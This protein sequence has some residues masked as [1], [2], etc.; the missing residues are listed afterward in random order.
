MFDSIAIE[1]HKK[2]RSHFTYHG[3][4]SNNA[5]FNR[6]FLRQHFDTPIPLAVATDVSVY[7]VLLTGK[8]HQGVRFS[9]ETSSFLQ[10]FS[11]TNLHDSNF[12]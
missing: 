11:S 3:I 10:C 6:T 12:R 2:D 1:H 7:D 9:M 5:Y 8:Y 4:T